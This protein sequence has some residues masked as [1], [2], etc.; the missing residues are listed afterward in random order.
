MTCV[1][2]QQLFKLCQQHDLKLSGSD[3]IHVVCRQCGAHDVC[4]SALLD[5][6]GASD[7]L[8]IGETAPAHEESVVESSEQER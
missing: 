4:P 6:T 2:L 8:S 5:E 7:A 3:L 1:H